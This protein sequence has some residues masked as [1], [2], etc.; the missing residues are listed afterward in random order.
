MLLAEAKRCSQRCFNSTLFQLRPNA[1][2]RLLKLITERKERKAAAYAQKK[3]ILS[4]LNKN[5]QV[6]NQNVSSSEH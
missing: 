1:A 3:H 5:P 2:I 6:K 4:K